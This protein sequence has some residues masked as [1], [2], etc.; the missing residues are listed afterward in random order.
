MTKNQN[1]NTGMIG[2]LAVGGALLIAMA[3]GIFVALLFFNV[4]ITQPM[5]SSSTTSSSSGPQLTIPP[6]VQSL[7]LT[8]RN[9]EAF[10]LD[11][12]SGEYALL[13]FGY[14]RC[15]DVCPL[16]LSDYK[17]VKRDLDTAAEQVD[18]VFF[19]VDGERDTPEVLDSYMGRFDENFVGLTTTDNDIRQQITQSFAVFYATREIEG[20]QAGYIV[21]HTASMF[22]LDAAGDVVKVFPFGTPPTEIAADIQSRL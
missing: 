8:N 14:T 22:L 7:E 2:R 20:T 17:R 5:I 4:E 13:S 10:A 18:F 6:Q 12:L 21:D 3:A 1:K 15:P 11:E 9:G 16:T 19:S